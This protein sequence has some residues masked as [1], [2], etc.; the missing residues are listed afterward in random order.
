MNKKVNIFLGFAI[1]VMAMVA[2]FVLFAPMFYDG[3]FDEN[4]GGSEWGSVFQVM[5]YGWSSKKDSTSGVIGLVVAFALECAVF[6]AGF[7]CCFFEGKK[8]SCVFAI[9]AILAIAAGVLLLMGKQ[10]YVS[11]NGEFSNPQLTS[12]LTLG[13]GSICSIVFAWIA[14]LLGAY[15]A[16]TNLKA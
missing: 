13:A 5:F 4:P 11:T 3:S 16:Y 1:V 9:T 14:G 6:V 8:A 7:I 10:L 2:V 15:G 12:S